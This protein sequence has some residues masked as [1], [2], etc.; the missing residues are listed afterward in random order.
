MRQQHFPSSAARG[1]DCTFLAEPVPRGRGAARAPS[2]LRT[3]HIQTTGRQS[4][5]RRNR[6]MST[7]QAWSPEW[8]KR[9]R[10]LRVEKCREWV[11]CAS[12]RISTLHEGDAEQWHTGTATHARTPIFETRPLAIALHFNPNR[13]WIL[14]KKGETEGIWA[15]RVPP[16]GRAV[17]PRESRSGQR[18]RCADRLFYATDQSAPG[19]DEIRIYPDGAVTVSAGPPCTP[20]RTDG[21]TRRPA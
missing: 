16:Q 8:Q 3:P 7:R 19:V 5:A 9:C 20:Q 15:R 6:S 10:T 17:I 12:T 21:R 18:P 2:P 14:I 11:V 1:D 13:G 4:V